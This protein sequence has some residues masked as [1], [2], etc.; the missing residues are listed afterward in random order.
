MP[1]KFVEPV[2]GT[3]YSPEF[4]NWDRDGICDN[5][6]VCVSDGGTVWEVNGSILLFNSYSWD[7]ATEFMDEW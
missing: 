1:C 4:F 2:V 7:G 5:E 6:G 3:R